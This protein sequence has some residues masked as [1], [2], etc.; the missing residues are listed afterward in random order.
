MTAEPLKRCAAS[1]RCQL[2][3]FDS[4]AAGL[5]CAEDSRVDKGR[6]EGSA[7]CWVSAGEKSPAGELRVRG[8]GSVAPQRIAASTSEPEG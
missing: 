1:A 4:R 5:E 3:I 6:G 2:E 8:S 7:I